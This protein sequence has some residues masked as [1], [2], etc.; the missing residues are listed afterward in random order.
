MFFFFDPTQASHTHTTREEIDHN[1]REESTL[2]IFSVSIFLVFKCFHNAV[3]ML[4]LEGD[5][6]HDNSLLSFKRAFHSTTCRC[7]CGKYIFLEYYRF[8]I[9][10]YLNTPLSSALAHVLWLYNLYIN[11]SIL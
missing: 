9:I 10:V 1:R 4:M 8:Q 11:L 7:F 6:K 5:I 3:S 2:V